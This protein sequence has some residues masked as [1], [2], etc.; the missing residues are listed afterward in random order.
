MA[1]GFLRALGR[2][3]IDVFSAGSDPAGSLNRAAVEAMAE[4]GIDIAGEAPRH[5]SDELIESVD[6][7]VTMGCG[8]TC[9]VFPGKRYVDWEIEDPAGKSLDQVRPIRDELERR[10]RDLMIEL[11]VDPSDDGASE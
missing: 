5:W 6:V 10:V 3:V 9:P 4:A 11:G 1:A 8:D 2:D 7:V